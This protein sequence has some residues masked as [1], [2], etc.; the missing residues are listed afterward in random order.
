MDKGELFHIVLL[1]Y[2]SIA[3]TQHKAFPHTCLFLHRIPHICTIS[4]PYIYSFGGCFHIIF[5]IDACTENMCSFFTKECQKN[6]KGS[7]RFKSGSDTSQNPKCK[8]SSRVEGSTPRTRS[9]TFRFSVKLSPVYNTHGFKSI[10][11]YSSESN[12]IFHLLVLSSLRWLTNLNGRI[13]KIS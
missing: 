2:L 4:C 8:A 5:I 6:N 3:S 7:R 1:T 9:S 10:L 13:F 11:Q 12:S